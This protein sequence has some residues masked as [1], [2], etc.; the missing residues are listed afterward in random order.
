MFIYFLTFKYKLILYNILNLSL[1]CNKIS[2]VTKYKFEQNKIIKY[3]F[4]II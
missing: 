2:S 3:M 4:Q 1:F